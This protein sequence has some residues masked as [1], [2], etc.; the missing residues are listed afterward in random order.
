MHKSGSSLPRCWERNELS[1]GE[2][3]Q[4]VAFISEEFTCTW[5]HQVQKSMKG[6]VRLIAVIKPR[7]A[8]WAQVLSPD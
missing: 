1:G 7:I 4:D 3:D 2:G 8:I 6:S 5:Q